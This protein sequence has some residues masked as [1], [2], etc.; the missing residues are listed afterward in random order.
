MDVWR[1]LISGVILALRPS[2]ATFT[3]PA[4]I[5][6][7]GSVIYAFA[8]MATRALRDTPNTVLMT[9]QLIGI[10]TRRKATGRR[11]SSQACSSTSWSSPRK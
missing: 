9:G 5:A 6:V 3:G 1:K 11:A 2:A 7:I 8:L 4:L 10:T